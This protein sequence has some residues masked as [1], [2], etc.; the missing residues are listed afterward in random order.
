MRFFLF[1]VIICSFASKTDAKL[2]E[3]L[4]IL[5]INQQDTI[6]EPLKDGFRE[7]Y[8]TTLDTVTI[9]QSRYTKAVFNEFIDY[10]PELIEDSWIYNPNDS[11][12][13]RKMILGFQA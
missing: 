8:Y 13:Q 11:Y 3:R 9:G 10:H 2:K 6:V 12:T 5:S 1:F 4:L 7:K